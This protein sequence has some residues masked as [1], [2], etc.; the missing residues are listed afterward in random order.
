VRERREVLRLDELR[1]ADKLMNVGGPEVVH[2][3]GTPSLDLGAWTV[4]FGGKV[5]RRKAS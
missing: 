1:A 2:P 3:V 4:P 5:A